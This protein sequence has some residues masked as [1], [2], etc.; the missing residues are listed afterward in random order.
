MEEANPSAF[1]TFLNEMETKLKDM[2]IDEKCQKKVTKMCVQLAKEHVK[3]VKKATKRKRH[4]NKDA[5]STPTT[6][7]Y[8]PT[9]ISP[10]LA[11]FLDKKADEEMQRTQIIK[12]IYAYIRE[13]GLM[14][15]EKRRCINPDAKLK[16]LLGE[17][18]FPITKQDEQMGY[19][20][21]NLNRYL[22]KHILA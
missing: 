12:A 2:V 16:A 5:Q 10:E 13:H 6:G 21:F 17:P 8:R 14:D 19:S 3:E 22:S 7:F 20:F 4:V 15:K 11:D 18:V 1:Q 9:K